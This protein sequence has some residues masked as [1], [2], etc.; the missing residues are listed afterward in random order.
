MWSADIAPL[1]PWHRPIN[2]VFQHYAL[3]PHLTVSGNVAFGLRRQGAPAATIGPRTQEALDLVRLGHLG[4]RYPSQLS[5][6]QQQRVALA[7]ALVLKPRMLLLD[8]PLSAL[9][10]A[11]RVQM[12]DELRELQQRSGIAFLFVTHDQGEA[13]AMSDRIAVIGHGRVHQLGSPREVYERPSDRYVAGFLGAANVLTAK[14]TAI[15][16]AFADVQV[17][18]GPAAR[19]SVGAMRPEVGQAVEIVLRPDFMALSTAPVD[20]FV[21]WKVRVTDRQYHGAFTQWRAEGLGTAV[22]EV[23]GTRSALRD[24]ADLAPGTEGWTLFPADAM[25]MLPKADAP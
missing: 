15:D 8:E 1:P 13:L 17:D 12:R 21:G 24:R 22:I 18:S 19:L 14:V 6:G 11:L 25:V 23:T 16:G 2:T 5:G 10:H 9:D 7:R 3:F 4:A 20:G